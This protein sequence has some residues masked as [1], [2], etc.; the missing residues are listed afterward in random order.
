MGRIAGTRT[1]MELAWQKERESQKKLINELNTMSRVLKST[2][3]EVEKEKERD[4]LDSKR[5]IE[6]MK[7]AFDEEQDDTKKQITDLQYDLL[8]LRDAHAKLRTTNEKLRRDKDKSVDDVRLASKTRS[9]Y[10]EEKKI[11]RLISDMDEFLGVLPKFLGSDIMEKEQSNGRASRIKDDEKSIA[12]MEF[13][14]AL[15]RVKETKEELE[16]LHRISEEEV[17]R[18]GNMRRGES[19]ESNVDAVD[20]PRGRS[21]VRNAGASASSQ[22]RAL[23]RKAVSMGDGMATEGAGIWQSKESVGS[24]ESLASNA[25]IPL[26]VPV[27]T[28]SARGGSESG[29]SSDTYNAMTIR[30]LERDTSVDRLSTGSRE[31]MQSTQSELLPGERKK[32][33]GLLGKL[34][35]ITNKKDRNISEEREFGSGSDISSVSVASKTSNASRVSTSSKMSTATKLIQRA[36]SASR[37]R[38]AKSD[39]ATPFGPPGNA[40]AAFDKYFEKAEAGTNGQAAKKETSTT[41]STSSVR[42]T[43]SSTSAASAGSSSTLPR[44]YRRF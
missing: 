33:K 7:R 41:S 38:V 17:K 44:T 8:E 30:R 39:K 37:D 31:S 4:R 32:S 23:Y 42:N 5:K 6:A 3:L 14:S 27:R 22:K 26:P 40:D 36:R 10:G 29:Y 9:E 34:K 19:V 1:K 21:G 43:S 11:Q 12:K 25:S 20:S 16:Q 18:R 28:R 15:F 24:N 2:L 13:K 35:N